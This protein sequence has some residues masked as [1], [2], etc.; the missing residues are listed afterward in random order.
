MC[1]ETDSKHT[2]I[3]MKIQTCHFKKSCDEKYK[4]VG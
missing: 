1:Y 4:Y 3:L 2:K